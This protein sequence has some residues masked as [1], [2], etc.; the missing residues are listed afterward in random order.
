MTVAFGYDVYNGPTAE[1]LITELKRKYPNHCTVCGAVGFTTEGNPCP[2]CVLLSK[3]PFDVYEELDCHEAHEDESD[4]EDYWSH[5]TGT[6]VKYP[7]VSCDWD[8][9]R[10]D[11]AIFLC[12]LDAI[13]PDQGEEWRN[14][15]S[16]ELL[17]HLVSE[18]SP[19]GDIDLLKVKLAN[20]S[21]S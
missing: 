7:E 8:Y 11:E 9:K 17:R 6:F 21:I 19:D 5:T 3:D 18:V 20:Y 10:S 13:T 12:V 1:N 14:L 2:G 16:A 4:F 15:Y